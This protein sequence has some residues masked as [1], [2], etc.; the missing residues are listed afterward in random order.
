[1]SSLNWADIP[2]WKIH[3]TT[4][5]DDLFH[6]VKVSHTSDRTVIG[7]AYKDQNIQISTHYSDNAR[8]IGYTLYFKNR[9]T[10]NGVYP[11]ITASASNFWMGVYYSPVK[12]TQMQQRKPM[13]VFFQDY[14]IRLLAFGS[15]ARSKDYMMVVRYRAKDS[16][17]WSSL[18]ASQQQE[19]EQSE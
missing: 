17:M 1:M 3:K 12:D 15:K 7:E 6:A 14:N 18:D 2:L 13:E 5:E 19:S 11:R 16:Y 9:T 8:L 4:F 10:P